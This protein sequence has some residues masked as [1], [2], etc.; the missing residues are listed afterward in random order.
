MNR[1]SVP[2]APTLVGSSASGLR[3]LPGGSCSCCEAPLGDLPF[4]L[5]DG[6]LSDRG[7]F[8]IGRYV[9]EEL[10]G[11]GG[12]A[13]VFGAR[14]HLLGKAVAIKVLRHELASDP[15]HAERF[16]RG[17][18]LASQL[19]H[20][21]VV[22]V[23]DFGRDDAHGLIYLVMDR[24]SGPTLAQ[25]LERT[26]PLSV[27]RS[28]VV[29][30]QLA[31]ALHH[32]HSRGVV[33]RDIHPGNVV[34]EDIS[35]R[36]DFAKLCDF[37]LSKLADAAE[38]ITLAGSVIG[39]PAYMAPEQIRGVEPLGPTV[40]VYAFG[41]TAYEMLSGT[42]PHTGASTVAMIASRL[43]ERATP[44]R[45]HLD[46]PPVLDDVVMRCL[47]EEPAGR[48][49]SAVEIEAALLGLGG[50]PS[51]RAGVS[52]I[53]H[54][55]ARLPVDLTGTTVGS[56]HVL[57]LV[58]SGG[59]GSVYLAEHPVIGSRVA[60]KVL[61]PELATR[62]EM[63]RRFVEEA[64]AC[65]AIGSAY[66][67]RYHD[68]GALSDGRPYAVM[69][70]LEGHTLEARLAA[71]G[72]LALE[73]V[74][75]TASQVAEAM[76]HAHAIGIVHCDLKPANIFLTGDAVKVLDFGIARAMHGPER[77]RTTHGGFLGSPGHCAPE[78]ISGDAVGPASDVYSLGSTIF[79][80]L[81]GRA[82]FEGE[83]DEILRA[84]ISSAAPPVR[85][86]RSDV[87]ARVGQTL[88][89]ML[90]RSPSD[91]V[92]NMQEV[93]A[94]IACWDEAP[95]TSADSTAVLQA[96]VLKRA[97]PRPIHL[98][99]GAAVAAFLILLLVGFAIAGARPPSEP[100]IDPA[101][102]DPPR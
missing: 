62:A 47:S 33:H 23:H 81:T 80:M 41:V 77:T 60:I 87:P 15:V 89:R 88:A 8:R 38:R 26:G 16:L 37:G 82:P 65:G 19:Q 4:C 17:A 99:A 34:L 18:R 21:H 79:E 64:R 46:L 35:G 56:Y 11:G 12:T 50:D 98:V 51:L 67:P 7:P 2:L 29:L 71:E 72:P 100:A 95:Y 83:V 13:L 75:S 31:S 44:L 69:E 36:T 57:S 49:A 92:A 43:T 55:A 96:L 14:H 66:I 85:E 97:S 20:P 32:A 54:V 74:V 40:D 42:L 93:G 78:Q 101:S 22:T 39:T 68:F 10:L 6:T 102:V 76:A 1:R 5:R 63:C 24:L 3:R 58:G 28:I 9:V 61:H 45:Q 94:E 48:P 84:K 52:S 25:V 86:L 30:R 73:T 70:Y 59:V 53:G 27:E 90:A 91:R